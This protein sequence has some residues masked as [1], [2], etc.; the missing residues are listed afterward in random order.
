MIRHIWRLGLGMACL[1][2]LGC[3][4]RATVDKAYPVSGTVTLD[5]SPMPDGEIR[6][7][8]VE[9]GDFQT[10]PIK[11]GKFKGEAKAG[12]RKVEICAFRMGQDKVMSGL[13][14]EGT[15]ENIIPAKY[16][17]QSKLTA[18]VKADGPNEFKFE[19]TSK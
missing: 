4:Q 6:F 2:L 9:K 16:N 10:V 7:W 12:K 11:D 15:R 1:V 13:K 5:G 14:V 3:G 18:E 8:A 19:I 17:T